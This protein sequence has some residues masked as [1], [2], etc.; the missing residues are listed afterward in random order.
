M[1]PLATSSPCITN[2]LEVEMMSRAGFEPAGSKNG[3]VKSSPYSRVYSCSF[4]QFT[5]HYYLLQRLRHVC[6]Y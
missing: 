5:R 4:I 2:F 6:D 1:S 3:V